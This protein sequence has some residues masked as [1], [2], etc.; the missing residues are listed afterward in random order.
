M[1]DAR[2]QGM[3]LALLNEV[4]LK[5]VYVTVIFEKQAAFFK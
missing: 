2:T 1:T 3:I 5:V 4:E